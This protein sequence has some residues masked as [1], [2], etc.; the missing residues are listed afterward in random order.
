MGLRFGLDKTVKEKDLCSRQTSKPDCTALGPG[1]CKI[2][3]YHFTFERI[4]I[5]MKAHRNREE[6]S[7]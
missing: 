3:K 7:E 5:L 1:F 6:M 4:T 2:V